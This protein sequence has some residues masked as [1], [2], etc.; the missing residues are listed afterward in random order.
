[1]G[2]GQQTPFF[3]DASSALEIENFIAI[4]QNYPGYAETTCNSFLGFVQ[5]HALFQKV[6]FS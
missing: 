1:M 6:K 3:T 2:N 5:D 4:F